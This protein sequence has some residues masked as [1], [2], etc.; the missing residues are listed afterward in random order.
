MT[1]SCSILLIPN[2]ITNVDEIIN[3]AEKYKDNFEYRGYI[4]GKEHENT[5]TNFSTGKTNSFYSLFKSNAPDIVTQAIFKT[6][7][8]NLLGGVYPD[9]WVI[10]RYEPGNYL[11]R[12]RDSFG[13]YWQFNLIFLRSDKPHFKYYLTDADKEGVLVKEQP[14]AFMQMPIQIEHEV[15]QIEPDESDRFSLVLIWE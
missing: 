5:F 14:G 8:I 9:N 6:I 13:K 11:D 3:L 12:H 2:L 7:D 15:T 10:N 4:D 1:D